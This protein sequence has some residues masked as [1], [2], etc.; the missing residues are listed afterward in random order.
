MGA[1]TV[2]LSG[3]RAITLSIVFAGEAG[4]AAMCL[5]VLLGSE[6][7]ARAAIIITIGKNLQH[8]FIT[9][10]TLLSSL[11]QVSVFISAI[12][13]KGIAAAEY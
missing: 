4:I 10:L 9:N 8:L 1:V 12:N 2:A 7:I 3:I 5:S 11:I 13:R 6:F